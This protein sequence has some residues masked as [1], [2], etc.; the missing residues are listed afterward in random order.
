MKCY[1][2]G[3][4]DKC[5]LSMDLPEQSL[6]HKQNSL[7]I[8]QGMISLFFLIYQNSRI[9]FPAR[10]SNKDSF[11]LSLFVL[12]LLGCQFLFVQICAL[13]E[14]VGSQSHIRIDFGLISTEYSLQ[15]LHRSN[16]C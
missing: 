10:Y 15:V 4:F 7:P 6:D 1:I 12:L 14:K 9:I 13:S 3:Y 2:S 11:V 16:F 5:S 8:E